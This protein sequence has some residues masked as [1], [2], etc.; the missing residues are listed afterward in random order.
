MYTE[1]FKIQTVARMLQEKANGI[2]YGKFAEDNNIPERTLWQWRQIYG[3]SMETICEKHGVPISEVTG[4]WVKGKEFSLRF[5]RKDEDIIELVKS[6]LCNVP[7]FNIKEL[8]DNEK[9]GILGMSDLHIGKP[10]T[11][12]SLYYSSAVEII[13]QFISAGCKKVLFISGN[14]ALNVDNVQLTTTRGTPQEMS[15][16]ITEAIDQMSSLYES[17]ILYC[18]AK[19]IDIV[20]VYSAANHD[21][22]LS[23]VVSYGLADKHNIESIMNLEAR[24]YIRYGNNLFGF[25]HGDKTKDE[26]LPSLMSVEKPLEWGI[27]KHRYFFRGHKHHKERKDFRGCTVIGMR[28]LSSSDK[29]HR[30]SG[31]VGS[32]RGTEGFL[33]DK[34]RG[35]IAEYLI[36]I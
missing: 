12:L 17:V 3:N 6:R 24:N 10:E 22:L 23:Y 11:D 36:T 1:D 18:K 20:M 9:I 29:W 32:P 7:L 35:I 21:H 4:G 15:V 2:S 34:N 25:T 26:Q 13:D 19:K 31:Y 16:S 5:K 33:V 30:D 27:T 8:E 28:S 14:D